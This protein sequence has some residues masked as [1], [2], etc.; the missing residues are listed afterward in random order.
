MS[1]RHSATGSLHPSTLPPT[2]T[3]IL[4]SS[5]PSALTRLSTSLPALTSTPA[6]TVPPT[7]SPTPTEGPVN[8]LPT[9]DGVHREA[10]VPI[11]MYHHIA[12]PPPDADPIRQDLSVSPQ[13]FEAQLRYLVRTGYR[14]ITL[15]DLVYHL[16][17]GAPLPEK[18][19]VLTFDDGYEDNYTNAYPLLKKYGFVGTFFIVTEPV[20]SERAGY[21]SWAQI[22][23]MSTN[24]ME[25]GAH[26]YTHP[27]LRDKPMDYI[28]WQAVAPKEAIEARIQ[29]PVRFF[30]YP[31][32]R[33]DEQ[34]VNVL[35]SANFWGAVTIET[36]TYQSSQRPFE[37]RRI[38]VR[39]SD[40]LNMFAQKLNLEWQGVGR[41]EIAPRVQERAPF[42]FE[43]KVV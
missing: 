5:P 15:R 10:R 28:I 3:P 22:E 8:P 19:I 13:A 25:I 14:P 21:M 18:P 16:T 27:D 36:G 40:T 20:D 6:P 33:Y 23:I 29:Q 42:D 35:R 32:G 24:G 7:L 41:G 43:N 2:R 37:L 38:R 4:W 31:S 12:D 9:P 39:G 34:V 17:L 30:S 11:L 1:L 26:S